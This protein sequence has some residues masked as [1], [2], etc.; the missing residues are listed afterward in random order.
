VAD[1]TCGQREEKER[2]CGPSGPDI[3]AVRIL[4]TLAAGSSLAQEIP[5]L[6]ELNLNL[7]EPNLIM[8]GEFFLP[9]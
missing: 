1:C 2:K 7:L 3:R 4:P 9:V 8:I 5:T 6:I